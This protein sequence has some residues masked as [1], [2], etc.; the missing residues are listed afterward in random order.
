MSNKIIITSHTNKINLLKKINTS[1]NNI[2]I[3]T[4]EEFNR[5]YYFDYNEQT[6]YYIMNKYNVIYEIAKIYLNNLYYIENKEYKNNKLSFLVSLKK[7]LM[8][9]KLLTHN[10]L[11]NDYISNKEIVFYNIPHTKEL[12]LLSNFYLVLLK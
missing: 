2:K 9:E 12:D 6:I 3:Y 7:E 5:L 8:S 4:L 11:F 10:P 1:L